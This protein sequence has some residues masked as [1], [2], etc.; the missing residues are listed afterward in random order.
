M[1]AGKN[2][3]EINQYQINQNGELVGTPRVFV[4][5]E[6]E[7]ESGKGGLILLDE[8][9]ANKDLIGNGFN[10]YRKSKN[11]GLI[12]YIEKSDHMLY[13][14]YDL[15]NINFF[16]K[17]SDYALWMSLFK[18]WA[19]EVIEAF[20]ES[21]VGKVTEEAKKTK[22][23]YYMNEHL[24]LLKSFEPTDLPIDF[25]NVFSTTITRIITIPGIRNRSENGKDQTI[26]LSKSLDFYL[27]INNKY[28][29]QDFPKD[30][31]NETLTNLIGE[32]FYTILKTE[33]Y[34]NVED[35]ELCRTIIG[36]LENITIKTS[37]D[38]DYVAKGFTNTPTIYTVAKGDLC[39]IEKKFKSDAFI[40]D[41]DWFVDIDKLKEELSGIL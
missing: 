26:E 16:E 15:L 20:M 35:P 4:N 21:C 11:E 14:P 36:T 7:S 6:P 27:D 33:S 13:S 17:E 39:R 9:M 25:C 40:N 24:E 3:E 37:L 28:G 23:K 18:S 8:T 29:T 30:K 32:R 19:I 34:M 38:K 31:F 10:E 1:I 12:E 22:M 5:I 2:I 41:L